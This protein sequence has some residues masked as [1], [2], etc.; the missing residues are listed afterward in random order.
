MKKKYKSVQTSLLFVLLV[1]VLFSACKKGFLNEKVYSNISAVNF[2]KNGD[3]ARSGLYATYTLALSFGPRDCRPFF[4]LTDMV[5]DDMDKEYSN[6]EDER[7]QI[8]NF[9]F[10]ANNSYF[11]NAWISLYKTIAQANDVIEHVPGIET[12]TETER[13]IMVG[14]ARFLRALEY[15][16]LVQLWGSVPL[17]TIVVRTIDQTLMPKAPVKE[18]YNQIINDLKFAETHCADAAPAVGRA[19][20]WAAKALLAKVYLVLAGPFSNRNAEMLNQSEALLK[21]II[22]SNNFQLVPNIID[23]FN[24]SKKSSTEVI[25]EHYTLGDVSD[26]VGSFLHRNFL[27]SSISAPEVTKL[28]TAGYKAWTPT[29]DLWSLYLPGDDR[30]KMYTSAYVKK[31][32]NGTFGIQKYNVPYI[33]K[34]VDSTTVAR[35]YKANNLPVIRY[36]DVLLMY[37]EVLNELEKPGPQGNPYYYLNLVRKRAFSKNPDANAISDG[38][39]SKE[40]FRNI[41]MRERRL[42]FAHEGQRLFDLKRTG[43]YIPVMTALAQKNVAALAATPIP[44][45]SGTYPAGVYPNPTGPVA[46]AA[47]TVTYSADFLKNTKV[48]APQPYQIVF[49]IPYMQLQT[50]DIGQN[51][52]YE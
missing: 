17:D 37:A 40:E 5:T 4:I 35:D 2:W 47:G 38:S 31:N 12:M 13:S 42:E 28:S 36:A 29:P 26:R 15:Y 1:I 33:M 34:Y 27:P 22:S 44:T 21:E 39:L 25:F 10:S 24:I 30:L 50:F 11:N 8:Q 6:S 32:S 51:E 48:V 45:W 18:I 23:Y 3:D 16:Y 43:T 19:S 20:K 7:R 49:P 9:N 46:Y 52:G 41:V 14:E